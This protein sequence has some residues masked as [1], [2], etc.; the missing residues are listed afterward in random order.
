MPFTDVFSDISAF[1]NPYGAP[2]NGQWNISKGIYTNSVGQQLVFFVEQSKGENP[3]QKTAIDQ[4][5]DSTGRRIAIYEYPY[6]DGQRT[7]DLGRKGEKFSFNIKFWGQ[8]YQFKY[9]E[10]IRVVVNDKGPGTLLHPTYSGIRGSIPARYLDSEIVHRYD[11]FNAVTLKVTFIEDNTGEISRRNYLPSQDSTLRSALQTLTNVQSFIGGTIFQVGA[12]LLLPKS[13][14][15]AMKLRLESIT[16]SITRLLGQLA[17]TFSSNATA[18]NILSQTASTGNGNV[19]NLNSGT[20]SNGVS[21]N[22]QL[23]PV[24][25]VGFDPATQSLI[26]SQIQNFINSNQVTTQQAVFAANQVRKLI[27][28]AIVEVN[29]NFGNSGYDVVLNYRT[30]AISIQEVVESCIALAQSNVKI[31]VVPSPMSLRVIAQKN[32]LNPDRQ[33]DI[34]SLNPYIGSINYIPRGTEIIVPAA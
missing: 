2:S 14:I 29:T 3:K 32:G 4:I 24:Y 21:Q 18:Q 26:T 23:P 15:N 27:S 8:D 19:A 1:S 13:M 9:Q 22:A 12:L 33:N 11:E 17:S 25:Q 6:I 31:Y 16:S 10:F 34:E 28:D 7:K 30:L 20:V 5:S